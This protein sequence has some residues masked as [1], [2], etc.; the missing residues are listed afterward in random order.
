MAIVTGGATGI[1][2]GISLA[3]LKFGCKVLITSRKEKV[4]AESKERLAKESGN[5]DVEYTTCD[6]RNY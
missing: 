5:N 2:Y 1:C 4:L 6:V 3:Y